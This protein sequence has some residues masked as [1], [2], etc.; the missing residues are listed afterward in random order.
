MSRLLPPVAAL[1]TIAC[2]AAVT[3]V[4]G[5]TVVA[6]GHPAGASSDNAHASGPTSA[7]RSTSSARAGSPSISAP[8]VARRAATPARAV[9]PTLH[10]VNGTYYRSSR[11]VSAPPVMKARAWAV[12]D[13]DSG[14]IIATHG[15]HNR[16]P[17][18]STI[19]LLTAVTAADR[20]PRLP[21]HRITQA[22]AHPQYCTCAGLVPGE[23]YTRKA[24][25]AGMLLPSGND[26]AEAIAGSDPEGRA[27]FI[28]A[29]NAKAKA[30][31]AKHTVVVT[32][33]GLTAEGAHST[34]YDLLVFLRAAIANP[35][36]EPILEMPSFQLGPRGGTTHLIHRATHYV[37]VYPGSLGKSGYTTPA[38]STL[39]V[40]TPISG[41]HIGVA[42]LGAPSGRSSTSGARALTRW[43]ASNFR[44]LVLLGRLPAAP[45]PALG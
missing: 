4:T 44:A 36:V 32:P 27:T 41:H 39:V 18:A 43:A 11:P 29:M 40:S 12:A 30:L 17:Q 1:A 20:V 16:L 33:S 8:A 38:K 9:R 37:N 13:L 23:R 14:R 34:A 6:A 25:L 10:L 15:R 3:A 26:A 2:V 24:L 28:A 22:E 21:S 45:G 31:G 19:K 35:V 5:V 7:S 42:T